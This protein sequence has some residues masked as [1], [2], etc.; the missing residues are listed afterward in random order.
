MRVVGAIAVCLIAGASSARAFAEAVP[1]VNCRSIVTPS[2]V[3]DFR[4]NRVVLGVFDVPPAFIQQTVE[5]GTGTWPYW[6]KA[7][8]VVR[9]ES[10]QVSVSVPPAWRTRVAIGWGNVDAS[11]A[12]RIASCPSSSG[13]G[14]WNVYAGGF[15][16][17]ARAACVPLV[18]RVGHRTA[19]VR[20]GIGKRCR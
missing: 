12:L 18:F 2:G 13:L 1:T 17:R 19:T 20:F 5:V 10:P 6:S 9:A 4:P 11:S 7:G 14:D 8:L 15:L 3:F 16:L